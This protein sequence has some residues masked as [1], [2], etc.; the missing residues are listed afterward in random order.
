[1]RYIALIITTV[2]ISCNNPLKKSIFEPLTV[3][4]LKKVIE[5]DT[6]FRENYSLEKHRALII[7]QG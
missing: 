5:K 2:F 1:M 4:E 7:F 6:S 3:E